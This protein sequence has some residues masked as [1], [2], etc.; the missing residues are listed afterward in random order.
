M[1]H[2]NVR[3]TAA[4]ASM[5]NRKSFAVETV[6]AG[7]L[8]VTTSEREGNGVTRGYEYRSVTPPTMHATEEHLAEKWGLP[9]DDGGALPGIRVTRSKRL[10]VPRT[11]GA[12]AEMLGD[13]DAQGLEAIHDT[14]ASEVP[15]RES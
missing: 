11:E 9:A 1:S 7:A 6:V 3:T 15:N 4:G 5:R 10:T 14:G 13:S 8:L 12:R 2:K